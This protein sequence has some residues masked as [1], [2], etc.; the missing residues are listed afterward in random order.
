M[1]MLPMNDDDF[2]LLIDTVVQSQGT[3]FALYHILLEIT[4]RLAQLHNDPSSYLKE[5]YEAIS[6]KIDKHPLETQQKRASDA[7][8]ETISTFFSVAERTVR[9]RDQDRGGPKIE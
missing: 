4:M 6:A 5:M 7:E 8:R 3:G 1:A 9:R 2:K